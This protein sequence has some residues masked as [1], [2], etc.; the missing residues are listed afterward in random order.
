MM[1]P[2]PRCALVAAVAC[3]LTGCQTTVTTSDG[4]PPAP[5]PVAPPPAPPEATPNAIAV[6]FGPKPVDTNGN[7]LPDA[8]SVT[9][10]L[11]A[12]PHPSPIHAEG[13]FG[14][15]IFAAGEA[16][17]PEVP[18][19]APL[20]TWILEEPAVAASRSRALAGACHEFTL[21][22]LADRGSDDLPVEAVDLVAW[23]DPA[24]GGARVWM[25]GVRGV[26]FARPL[27]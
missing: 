6:T 15:A 7:R 27:R 19:S 23:F 26:Q 5:K 12:R 10:Y 2:S 14:F 4:T 25:N 8:L 20:R 16:G 22:L 1:R 24:G 3:L 13:V 17:T 9:A 18:R 11:F 21:S